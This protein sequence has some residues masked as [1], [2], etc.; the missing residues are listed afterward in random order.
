MTSHL[1]LDVVAAGIPCLLSLRALPLP[2]SLTPRKSPCASKPPLS[3]GGD[4]SAAG[5]DS[6]NSGAQRTSAAVFLYT[7][8]FFADRRASAAADAKP[9]PAVAVAKQA[10][11]VATG[12]GMS[13]VK[14][15]QVCKQREVIGRTRRVLF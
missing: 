4:S 6:S 2:P 7:P 3:A 5:G 9:P 11:R 1:S 13:V 12:V 15:F 8:D 14:A 10:R